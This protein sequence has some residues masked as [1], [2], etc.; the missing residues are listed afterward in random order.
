MKKLFLISLL[1]FS[2]N[3]WALSDYRP[4]DET[5]DSYKD[6][7]NAIKLADES[8]RHILLTMGGNWCPDCRTLGEYFTREDIKDW[9]DQRFIVVPVDVGE[10]DKNLD[11]AERYGNPISEGI[12]ALVVLDTDEKIV[13]ATL[14]GE[15]ATARSLSGE[16]LIEWLKVKIEPLLN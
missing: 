15:L 16:D 14:A 7:A 13:F 5:A 2:F 9:L 6:I 8:E 3:S 4:Y 11:I 1:L 12:P 10:W